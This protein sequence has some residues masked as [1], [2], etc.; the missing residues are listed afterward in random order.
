MKYE[1]LNME[2]EIWNNDIRRD[3]RS[4]IFLEVVGLEE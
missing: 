1:K 3:L 4:S 2:Y